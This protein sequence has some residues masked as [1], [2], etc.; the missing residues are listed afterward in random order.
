MQV[1]L[2][3]SYNTF[4]ADLTGAELEVFTRIANK[5]QMVNSLTTY[6]GLG[7]VYPLTGSKI[8]WR[9]GVNTIPATIISE[10]EA[11]DLRDKATLAGRANLVA[12]LLADPVDAKRQQGLIDQLWYDSIWTREM[13]EAAIFVDHG[14]NFVALKTGGVE[15]HVLV[16]GSVVKP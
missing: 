16:D 5:L 4:V 15:W 14:A 2:N 10:A 11:K 8:D 13:K 9:I 1:E 12:K 7:P 3:I 6:E